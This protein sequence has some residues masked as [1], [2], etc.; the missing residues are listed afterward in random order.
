[1]RT[2][3]IRTTLAVVAV[4]ASLLTVQAGAASAQNNDEFTKGQVEDIMA[5]CLIRG[6]KIFDGEAVGGG[7]WWDCALPDGT[8]VFCDKGPRRRLWTC[9][10]V[11]SGDAVAEPDPQTTVPSRGIE[12]TTTGT[13]APARSGVS[14]RSTLG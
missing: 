14:G 8:V 11:K 9:T 1:M 13:L 6:G 7:E 5:S 4:C 3:I 2:P 12:G 10:V